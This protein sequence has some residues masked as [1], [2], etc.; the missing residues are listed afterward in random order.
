VSTP[1]LLVPGT[2]CDERVFGPVLERLD[3][4]ARSLPPVAQP[5]VEEAAE[6]LLASAPPRFVAGGFSLGGFVVLELLRRAPERLAGAVLIASHAL[7]LPR[8]QAGARR[9]EVSLLR[10]AGADAL[11]DRLW[12]RYVAK[13][14]RGDTALR[15]M[16]VDMA[17]ASGPDL[18][19]AQTELGIS[20]PDSRDAVRASAV[21][22]LTLCG[23]EDGMC[24]PDRCHETSGEAV[25][26]KMLAGVGH[27]ITLEAPDACADAIAAW[28]KEHAACC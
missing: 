3:L 23:E 12:P 11:I 17:R 25:T 19:A 20:R 16:V 22:V 28:L 14:R 10:T 1:L 4:D 5:T 27:F 8:S 24:P 6:A 15:Q 18:F 2:L 9:A 7:P 26:S 13:R 21:P